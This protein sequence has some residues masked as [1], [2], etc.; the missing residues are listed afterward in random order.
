MNR[1]LAL[2]LALLALL[3][4][5]AAAS[6]LVAPHEQGYSKSINVDIV[7]GKGTLVIAPE[8]PGRRFAFGSDPWGQDLFSEMVHGL[9]WTLSIVIVTAA[10]RCVLGLGLG[11]LLAGRGPRRLGKRGFSPLSALPTF[12][13]A[14]LA[15]YPVTVNTSMP[16]LGL[17]L[18]Q[19]LILVLVEL[20]PVA[21][22]FSAKIS[23]I[24][25]KPFVEAARV[26]GADRHWL[27]TRHALPFLAVDFIEAL[28]T[29][30]L[31]AA[32]LIGKLGIVKVFIGGTRRSYDPLIQNPARSEWLG[33]LG[34]YREVMF[35]KPWLFVAPF[36][37]WLLVLACVML[38]SSGLRVHYARDRRVSALM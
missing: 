21:A 7:D 20:W 3:C 8:P 25:D 2:G 23:A 32:S 15:L 31:A 37:G 6:D 35:D 11:L 4:G 27:V 9:P 38:L 22:S 33:L 36:A 13:I 19:A 30:A 28:P 18:A 12:I 16:A 26:S 34:N 14:A 10:M 29:Q 1:Q 17:F 5:L 24:L